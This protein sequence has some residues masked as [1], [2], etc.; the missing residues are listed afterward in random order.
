MGAQRSRSSDAPLDSPQRRPF[1][2]RSSSLGLAGSLL[3]RSDSRSRPCT[4]ELVPTSGNPD[5]QLSPN[6]GARGSVDDADE[7]F[8]GTWSKDM[9]NCRPVA[10]D[11]KSASANFG[12]T[13]KDEL[14]AGLRNPDQLPREGAEAQ[15]EDIVV[16]S[17]PSLFSSTLRLPDL[18]GPEAPAEELLAAKL[19]RLSSPP[20]SHR[21]AS[22]SE[23]GRNSEA[24][25]SHF[26]L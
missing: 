4:G 23:T 26:S 1:G 20:P 5:P 8:G 25:D 14:K 24:A 9:R 6:F 16:G 13:L 10:V 21:T 19:S 22:K 11:A 7:S 3:A 17:Q 18:S 2:G 12:D 15:V